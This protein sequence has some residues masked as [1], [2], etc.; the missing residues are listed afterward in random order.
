MKVD[1]SS[2]GCQK[3]PKWVRITHQNADLLQFVSK[4]FYS[5]SWRKKYQV[6]LQYYATLNAF[7]HSENSFFS[8]SFDYKVFKW[9][10]VTIFGHPRGIP[11]FDLAYCICRDGWG[12]HR[13]TGTHTHTRTH[14]KTLLYISRI[15]GWSQVAKPFPMQEINCFLGA[16]LS[17]FTGAWGWL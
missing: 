2:G 8:L 4:I 12:A 13:R 9:F 1:F 7:G 6:V 11:I 14:I 3:L 16:D 15:C 17:K 10:V 5:K